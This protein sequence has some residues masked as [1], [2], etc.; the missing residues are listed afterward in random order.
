[1]KYCEKYF[2][3]DIAILKDLRR[4]M[5]LSQ[6]QLA[7]EISVSRNT[8]SALE[9]GNF[10]PSIEVFFRLVQFFGME[11]WDLMIQTSEGKM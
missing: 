2:K 5:K 10:Q 3:L 11:P 8:I 6:Q 4:E 9:N 7:N 1:M